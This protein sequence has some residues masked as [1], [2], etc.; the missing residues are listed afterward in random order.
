MSKLK[1]V[2]IPVVLN[3]EEENKLTYQE[4]VKH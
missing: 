3:I 2:N 1:T 4:K